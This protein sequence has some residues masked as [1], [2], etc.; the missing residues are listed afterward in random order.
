MSKGSAEMTEQISGIATKINET[1]ES[2]KHMTQILNVIEEIA[3]QTNLY[4]SM[5]A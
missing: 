4:L 5:Q 3:V 2:I 1:N